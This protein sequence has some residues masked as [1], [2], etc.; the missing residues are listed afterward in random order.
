MRKIGRN[1]KIRFKFV[2]IGLTKNRQLYTRE[3]LNNY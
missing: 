2:K 3:T 1:Y